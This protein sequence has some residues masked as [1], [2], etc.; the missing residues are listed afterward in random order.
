MGILSN[1]QEYIENKIVSMAKK[2]GDNIATVSALSPQQVKQMNERRNR[3]MNAQPKMDSPESEAFL[4]KQL[5]AIGIEVYQ[6]YLKQLDKIY[7]PIDNVLENFDTD[8]RIRYFDITRWVTDSEERDLDK[9][10]N[11]YH[12]LSEENCNIALIY[13]RTSTTCNVTLGVV[14]TDL[15]AAD[16]AIAD[17]YYSRMLGAMKGNFPGA[18]IREADYDYGVGVPE[19]L[20]DKVSDKSLESVAIVSNVASEKSEKFISQSIEKLFDGIVPGEG[21]DYTIVL[22]AKPIQNQLEVKNRLYELSSLLSPYESWQTS[23]IHTESEGVGA[24]ATASVNLGSGIG[25]SIAPS[26]EGCSIGGVGVNA[27]FGVSFS[28]AS[29]VSVQL[30]KNEGLTQTYKN[31]GVKHS[32]EIIDSQIKRVEESSAL[33]MWDFSA[34]VLSKSP[35]L[36]NNVAHMYL[37]LTQGEDSFVNDSSINFWD[38]EIRIEETKI[39]LNNV[40]RLLHPVFGLKE[41]VND[42]WL[43][44]PTLVTPT[45]AIS[46]K[47][48]AKAL[49]FPKKSVPGLPVIVAVSFGREVQK[50]SNSIKNSDKI[51]NV[52]HIV[53]MHS[54]DK[55]KT[56]ELDANSLTSHTFITGSTGTGKTT[57]TLQLISK[58][59]KLGSKI[60]VIEPVKG[61]YKDKIG[62]EC[63]VYG[64]NLAITDQ[65]LKINPFWFP[66]GIHVLEHIDRLI[67]ILNACWPMYAAMPAVLKDAVERAYI[68]Q[69][70]NLKSGDYNDKFPTFYDLLETLPDVMDDSMYS[71]DTKSDYSG[72]LI[73][74][75]KSLTNGLNGVIFCDQYG[76]SEKALFEENVIVDISRIGAVETKSLIMGILIMKLQ[77]YWLNKGEFSSELKHL[78]VLEEA[79]NILKRTSTAQ[80][81]EGSNLQGK[82][83]EMITNA[84]AEMRAYGEGFVIA[85]QAPCLLDEAV[86]R[87]TNT[88]I[89]LRLPDADDRLVVG[90]SC[91]LTDKQIDEIG[92]LPDHVA[93]VYQNDWLEAV[94]CYFED[95]ID[96][97][98]YQK[99]KKKE[100]ETK[101][102][103]QLKYLKYLFYES[104]KVELTRLERADALEWVDT[105]AVSGLT[106]RMLKRAF[107][108]GIINRKTIAYNLFHGK[109][110]AKDLEDNFDEKV[111]IEVASKRIRQTY[112]IEDKNLVQQICWYIILQICDIKQSG[113]FVERY[114][115][116]AERRQLQ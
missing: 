93:A 92:K 108:E 4:Q 103:D 95:F 25:L 58:A 87:N 73:T 99:S 109:N 39:I 67:E 17:K 105:L 15:H 53:H 111:A 61:E 96:I 72:A 32:L 60:L 34:Y 69:G 51:L 37:A 33:G 30:G 102:F 106:R 23:Y 47:E 13:N 18:E 62:G 27:N 85:D 45:V 90:K 91:S 81:Q 68:N 75:I 116:I 20:L 52:G 14:N 63:T 82:S 2:T 78:T 59:K 110:V 44:Y 12:V 98:K 3:Y 104:E 11:V 79:H 76:L 100:L 84:I 49:N 113:S 50:Y 43:M 1:T 5:G 97:S 114:K 38:G 56:V 115:N 21:E 101:E 89:V 8:N 26:A 107:A 66:E 94:L 65:I 29:N 74:R 46:G 71:K 86:I 9:L 48:L 88:K 28:R 112:N 19:C 42:E 77:E 10:I 16:P 83:V 80:S 31:Y 40:C 22:L 36:A 6:A 57:A 7:Y 35:T 41:S 55:E 70:W 54:I 24:S 64:T